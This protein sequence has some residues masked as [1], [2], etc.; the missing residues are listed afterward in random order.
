[1]RRQPDRLAIEGREDALGRDV[2]PVLAVAGNK[3][4]AAKITE[5]KILDALEIALMQQ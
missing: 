4:P 3:R 2:I 5:R 1:M